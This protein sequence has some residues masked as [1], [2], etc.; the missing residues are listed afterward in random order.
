MGMNAAS[1]EPRA[2]SLH[3][4]MAWPY[5]EALAFLEQHKA[6][7][8][9][10]CPMVLAAGEHDREVITLGRHTPPSDLLDPAALE[11]RGVLLRRVER[12]GGATAHGPGQLVVYPVISLPRLGLDVP[13][14]TGA[15]E[16]SAVALLAELG[17]EAHASREDRG[18]YV[19]GAKIGSVGFRVTQGVITHGMA[20]NVSNKLDLFGLIATC[21]VRSRPMTSVEQETGKTF[22][23]SMRARLAIHLAG[24][25]ASRCVLRIM[26]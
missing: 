21:G 3:V 14:L 6:A 2:A 20:L 12:G 26:G 23:S 11:A 16:A 10:G 22:E 4:A 18:V 25:V 1:G 8:L 9:E 24:Q 7:V 13:G 5:D 15:L 17:I 19:G